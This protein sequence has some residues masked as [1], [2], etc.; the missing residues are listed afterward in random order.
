MRM[1]ASF[2]SAVL[3][4]ALLL[5]APRASA[6]GFS[7]S[8]PV[9]EAGGE[10]PIEFTGD[11]EGATLPLAWSGAPAGTKAFALLMHHLDP[12]GV[13]KW[14]WILYAIPADATSL[15]RNQTTLG[16]PGNNSVNGQVGYAPPH[17]KGPGTKT[18]VYTLYALSAPLVLAGGSATVDR[19]ALLAALAGKVLA[20]AELSV[21]YTRTAGQT[22]T[23]GSPPPPRP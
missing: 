22:D 13:E 4:V 12:E 1:R 17:S 10:L 9:V 3:L 16:I 5:S 23:G 11:G 19:A 8:S 14:Y 18:Y 2:F 20:T 15:A 21:T 6:N 7:L